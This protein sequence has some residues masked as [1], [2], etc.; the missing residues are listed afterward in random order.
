MVEGTSETGSDEF[1]VIFPDK[2]EW[3][4]RTPFF[5]SLEKNGVQLHATVLLG[6]AQKWYNIAMTM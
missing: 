5:S 2:T 1:H 3:K 6:A 4:T